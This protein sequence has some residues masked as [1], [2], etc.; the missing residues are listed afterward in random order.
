MFSVQDHFSVGEAPSQ[1]DGLHIS[2]CTKRQ[3][4]RVS[5]H[6]FPVGKVR[7]KQWLASLKL[8]NPRPEA[9]SSMFKMFT[10][11]EILI[12]DIKTKWCMQV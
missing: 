1:S 5:F 2:S 4:S 9:C 8:V 10:C 6:I 3:A 7:Q 12:R 11:T